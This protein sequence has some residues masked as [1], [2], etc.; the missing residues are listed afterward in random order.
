VAIYIVFAVALGLMRVWATLIYA[1]VMTPYLLA[2]P[3]LRRRGYLKEAA[4]GP[5]RDMVGPHA[6]AVDTRGVTDEIRGRV[7]FIPWGEVTKLEL[8]SGRGLILYG[9]LRGLIVPAAT[10]QGGGFDAFWAE[11]QALWTASRTQAPATF[12]G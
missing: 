2:L 1:A 5:N 11:A 7:E 12:E 9:T 4:R 6:L 8:V 3:Y 10:V